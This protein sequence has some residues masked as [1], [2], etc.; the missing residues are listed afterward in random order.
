MQ[1]KLKVRSNVDFQ[2]VR[3][4]SARQDFNNHLLSSCIIIS[5]E[6]SFYVFKTSGRHFTTHL[7]IWLC[8]CS[9]FQHLLVVFS[10]SYRVSSF[11]LWL[12]FSRRW[13]CFWLLKSCLTDG[14]RKG[15]K[16][17][18]V[19]NKHL[20][21]LSVFT[22][23]SKRRVLLKHVFGP[24]IE[25]W[26][27]HIRNQHKILSQIAFRG[28]GWLGGSDVK[29]EGPLFTR[30]STSH[31]ETSGSRHIWPMRPLAPSSIRPMSSSSTLTRS[32]STHPHTCLI[33]YAQ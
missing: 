12:L 19:E 4:P 16:F 20:I 30:R 21:P 8:F 28:W 1:L 26:D 14:G 27:T 13:W 18:L 7:T 32:P 31:P 9:H 23:S 29:D 5:L 33:T 11:W 10:I 25:I 6:R 17:R 2:P 15:W 24:K 3:P 22:A